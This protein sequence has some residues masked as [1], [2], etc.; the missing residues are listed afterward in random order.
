MLDTFLEQNGMLQVR[1]G[2]A[3]FPMIAERYPAISHG[4]AADFPPQNYAVASVRGNAEAERAVLARQLDFAR[5]LGVN[6]SPIVMPSSGTA[7]IGRVTAKMYA[8]I[9][10]YDNSYTRCRNLDAIYTR[11]PDLLLTAPL[12]DCPQLLVAGEGCVGI[13]H[14]NRKTLDNDILRRFLAE[15]ECDGVS[16]ADLHYALPPAISA[17]QFRH[18]SSYFMKLKRGFEWAETG[19]IQLGDD[20]FTLDLRKAIE[21]DLRAAGV[22]AERFIDSGIDSVALSEAALPYGGCIHSKRV[23]GRNPEKPHGCGIVGIVRHS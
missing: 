11:A 21:D 2:V 12:S 23:A 19:A 9:R 22:P 1:D 10:G 16:P 14:A 4:F 7:E 6:V 20:S 5:A 17:A 18:G 3:R 15:L 8:K 13:V